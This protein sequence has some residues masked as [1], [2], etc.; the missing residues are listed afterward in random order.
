M[1]S[2]SKF[3]NVFVNL[4]TDVTNCYRVRIGATVSQTDRND[5]ILV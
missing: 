3:W 5:N 4:M 1:K 2:L